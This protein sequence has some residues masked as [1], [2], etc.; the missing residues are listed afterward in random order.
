[1]K[2]LITICALVCLYGCKSTTIDTDSFNMPESYYI[3]RSFIVDSQQMLMI[4]R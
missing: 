2:K 1:M 4:L 3:I